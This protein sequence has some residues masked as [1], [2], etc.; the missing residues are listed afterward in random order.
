MVLFE[1][2]QLGAGSGLRGRDDDTEHRAGIHGTL[3]AVVAR[4]RP[5]A[6]AGFL[7]LVERLAAPLGRRHLALLPLR[8]FRGV[9]D[10]AALS[11]RQL[12]HRHRHVH[13]PLHDQSRRGGRAAGQHLASHSDRSGDLP[14]SALG[15]H[16]RDSG[17]TADPLPHPPLAGISRRGVVSAGLRGAESGPRSERRKARAQKRCLPDQRVL[18]S[19]AQYLGIR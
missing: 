9:P 7:L 12:D 3:Y 16:G 15:R 8:L 13:Q 17:E 5:P 14:A 2:A 10:R 18:Q 6:A 19:E 11:V 4:R 1:I